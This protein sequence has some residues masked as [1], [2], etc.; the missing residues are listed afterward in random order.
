M[1]NE[2]P[3]GWDI[4]QRPTRWDLAA[5]MGPAAGVLRL[6]PPPS[7]TFSNRHWERAMITDSTRPAARLP[8]SQ[9]LMEQLV[10][11]GQGAFAGASAAADKGLRL[12]RGLRG[13]T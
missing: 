9:K 12:W 5:Q 10:P 8:T 1:D 11:L 3:E 13:G 2:D 6:P 4:V 7:D